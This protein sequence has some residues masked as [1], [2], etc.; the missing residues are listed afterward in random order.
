[1]MKSELLKIREP[2]LL[3]GHQQMLEDPRDGLTLFGPL[4]EG[5]PHGI[6]WGIVGTQEGMRRFKGWLDKIQGPISNTPPAEARPPFPGFEAAFK[7]PWRTKPEIE[8]VIPNKEIEESVYIDEKHQRVFQTVSVYAQRIIDATLKEDVHP[9]IWFVI[10][11]D[12]IYRYCHPQSTVEPEL[13]LKAEYYFSKK[14]AQNLIEQGSLFPKDREGAIPYEYEVN[15]HNQLKARLLD[16][17]VPTQ[18]IRESTIAYREFLNKFGQPSRPLDVME[19]AI[20][21]NIGAAVFYK[22]GG[23]PWKI[24]KIRDGVCYIGLVFKKDER[25]QNPRAAC[26]GAQ[27]FLDS[28]DGLVFKGDIGPWYREGE[29]TFHL[30]RGA[31]KELIGKAL[32][33]YEEKKRKPPK[34]LFIHGKVQFDNEEWSGFQDAVSSATNLIGVCIR[35]SNKIKLYRRGNNPV[36]RGISYVLDE[37]TA[38]LWTKGFVPRLNTYPGREVPNPLLVNVC[39]GNAKI[40]TVLSDIMGLTKLNYNSC[41]FADGLPVTLRFADAIGEILTAGPSKESSPLPFKYYI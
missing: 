13:R 9:D 12:Y 24:G 1:M 39:R 41:Q 29:G 21:W 4:D 25:K 37:N 17:H 36:L 38:F 3:F 7:I 27:M 8:L 11:P 35:P 19:S 6:R 10:I 15:F 34:E 2:E 30:K 18:I 16:M 31:A 33:T 5:S 14:A 20:A 22:A 28:G 26:C 32:K 23:R 40:E